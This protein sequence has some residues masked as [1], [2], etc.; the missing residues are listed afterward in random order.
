MA[1][2]ISLTGYFEIAAEQAAPPGARALLAGLESTLRE[3]GL[4]AD[5]RTSTTL[6]FEGGWRTPWPFK[7]CAGSLEVER[8]GEAA[9]RLAY[10]L[11]LQSWAMIMTVVVPLIAYLLLSI[12]PGISPVL[13]FGILLVCLPLGWLAAM[14]LIH[15]VI[16]ARVRKH[17]E[18]VAR[19]LPV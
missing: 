10:H 3:A 15:R 5:R 1:F 4:K 19:S 18:Q 7:S 14:A 11:S 6:R 8:D 2:P 12:D 13:Q 16:G 9:G 17:L